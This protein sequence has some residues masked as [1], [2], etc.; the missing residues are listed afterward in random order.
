MGPLQA[1]YLVLRQEHGSQ[2]WHM[3]PLVTLEN[4][5]TCGKPHSLRSLWQPQHPKP[6]R[7]P[8][9]SSVCPW[10]WGKSLPSVPASLLPGCC[11]PAVWF[12]SQW[13]PAEPT[14][15]SLRRHSGLV[16][17]SLE[18]QSAENW[19]ESVPPGFRPPALSHA[20]PFVVGC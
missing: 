20:V 11:A 3:W 17:S 9:R 4:R 15:A 14:P 16:L 7:N 12:C 13:T 6:F 19:L 10:T 8:F 5:I 18:V 1:L 2:P